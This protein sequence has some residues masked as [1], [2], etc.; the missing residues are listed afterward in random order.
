MNDGYGGGQ[1]AFADLA[2]EPVAGTALLFEHEVRHKGQPV[3]HGCKYVLRS[4][5]MYR[6][7]SG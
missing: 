7:R 3:T 1:T 2:V 4:D 5:V 6:F